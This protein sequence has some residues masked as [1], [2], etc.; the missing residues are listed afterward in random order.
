MIHGV[1]LPVHRGRAFPAAL[2]QVKR[3]DGVLGILWAGSSARGQADEHSD[4][5]FYVLVSGSRRWRVSFMAGGAPV[6]AFYNP[7]RQLRREIEQKESSTLFMLA[8]GR[9]MMGHPDL[10]ELISEARQT[11]ESGRPATP[12]TEFQRHIGVDLVWEARSTQGQAIHSYTC[13]EAVKSLVRALYQQRG[14]WDVNGREP[15]S[16][17][18]LAVLEADTDA[19]QPALEAFALHVLGS[20]AWTESRTEAEEV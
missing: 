1:S 14:W 17:E 18:L 2:E 20:L 8:G 4:L 15:E 6:E 11:L 9:V 16:A 10:D 3:A 13:M 12:L 5:D 7:A 19:R